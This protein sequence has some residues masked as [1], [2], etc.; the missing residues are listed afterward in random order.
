MLL[1]DAARMHGYISRFWSAVE[2]RSAQEKIYLLASF[3][4]TNTYDR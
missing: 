2:G 1:A 4:L 3:N